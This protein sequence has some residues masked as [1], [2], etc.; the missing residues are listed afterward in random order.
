MNDKPKQIEDLPNELFLEIFS[1]ISSN[2]LFYEWFNLNDRINAILRSVP[3]RVRIKTNDEYNQ[4]VPFLQHFSSQ[5]THLKDDRVLP[6]AGVDVRLL[7]NVRYLYLNLCSAEQYKYIHPNNQP[8]LTHFFSLILPWSVYERILF[9]PDRFP[10]LESVGCPPS[11]SLSSMKIEQRINE[12]IRHLH[13]HSATND[14]IVARFLNFFPSIISLT[15]D[16]L[17]GNR[18]LTP[19]SFNI[20]CVHRLT[21]VNTLSS[22]TDFEE[23]LS[24]FKLTDLTELHVAFNSCNFEQLARFLG[25]MSC[26]K[27]F[28][29]K[30]ET[31][32]S[33]A[34]LILIRS[35]S[36]WFASLDYG[37]ITH[38]GNVK[39]ILVTNIIRK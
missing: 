6:Y 27:Q 26:L 33:E 7:T 1:Y 16:H 34:D 8:Y 19:K 9:G 30:V 15:I 31:C 3:M 14:T 36:P 37:H 35:M 24:S 18:A 13:L 38:I 11:G 23:F 29:L 39:R 12:T 5:I 22:Q 4:T 2:D 10:Y 17:Y 32:P 25:Q 20:S 28:H 21:I